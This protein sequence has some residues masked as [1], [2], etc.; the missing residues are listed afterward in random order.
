M[1]PLTLAVVFGQPGD[2]VGWATQEEVP[3]TPPL[4]MRA[5]F[6]L[7][8]EGVERP[9]DSRGEIIYAQVMF[10]GEGDDGR[11]LA[12]LY[13]GP[14]TP[15][16]IFVS[17]MESAKWTELDA[18]S[19]EDIL[20]VCTLAPPLA[21]V[22]EVL[23]VAGDPDD[24]SSLQAWSRTAVPSDPVLPAFG[25]R[26]LMDAVE[27]LTDEEL[28]NAPEE[29]LDPTIPGSIKTGVSVVTIYSSITEPGFGEVTLWTK[30]LGDVDGFALSSADWSQI[31]IP[32]DFDPDAARL[33]RRV[34]LAMRTNI[35]TEI[36]AYGVEH[37]TDAILE[38]AEEVAPEDYELLPS[39]LAFHCQAQ[40]EMLNLENL[41]EEW[42]ESPPG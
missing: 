34:E 8:E 19:A 9:E 16:D 17:M 37:V 38:K 14:E 29:S 5:S 6:R 42:K 12:F 25:Q 18:P 41:M 28:E 22:Q 31:S 11:H 23:L 39:V 4:G 1:I 32:D 30:D 3:E 10:A 33:A 15:S 27:G 21:A 20:T 26:L 24:H 7:V 2:V 13:G 35:A 40:R 36:D